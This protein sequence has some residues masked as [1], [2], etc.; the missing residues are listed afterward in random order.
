MSAVEDLEI[1]R[2]TEI[3]E[4][5]P[6]FKTSATSNVS[7]QFLFEGGKKPRK[8]YNGTSKDSLLITSTGSWYVCMAWI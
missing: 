1:P 2:E 5:V 4:E 6:N 7:I 3:L 8:F